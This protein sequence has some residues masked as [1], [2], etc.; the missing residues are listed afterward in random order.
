MSDF[1]LDGRTALVTGASRGLGAAIAGTLKEL[2][3]SVI[4]TSRSPSEAERIADE[5][6]SRTLVLDID[7]IE[8]SRA[9]IATLVEDGVIPDLLVNNAGMNAPQP[10]IEVEA[11]SWDRVYASNVRGTFFLSQA[12][13]QHWIRLGIAG[14]IVTI[15]SQAGRVAIADRAAYGS[16]KAA[17]EQLTRNLAFEWAGHGI[18]VNAVAP[19]F[20]RTE[21]TRST[22]EDPERGSALLAGIPLG[23]FGEAADVAGPVAF[24]LGDA[25]SM[26]TGHT[27][28]VDGGF[29]I[30]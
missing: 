5:L 26:I 4:G 7:D 27:L 3:A 24:L 6:G 20:V 11:D 29:T 1:R 8:E 18:R 22:L 10:A 30:H 28:V 25:A 13:A 23:R 19:T 16:S 12:L 17:V 9:A 2:G 21:L 15:G 14:S